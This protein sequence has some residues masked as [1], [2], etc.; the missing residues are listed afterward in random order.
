[1]CAP[2]LT[3]PQFSHILALRASP[4]MR[5][6]FVCHE[7]V[8]FHLLYVTFC[9]GQVYHFSVLTVLKMGSTDYLLRQE[10]TANVT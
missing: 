8:R 6:T 5:L 1:M 10:K 4:S 2:L 3:L 7:C 9:D